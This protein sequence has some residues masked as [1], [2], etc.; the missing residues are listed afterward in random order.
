MPKSVLITGVSS[1]IGAALARVYLDRGYVVGGIARRRPEG[2]LPHPNMH[3]APA[4]LTDFRSV[5][6]A[7]EQLKARA[8]GTTFETLFLNAGVY[9]PRPSRAESVS[10]EAFM[11]VL[12]INVAG[13]KATMD[14]CLTLDH[15]PLNAIASASI[16]GRRP[17]M[18]MSTYATSK[19]ALNALIKVYQLEN[20]DIAFLALGM[21][22]VRTDL[23]HAFTQVGPDLRELF[24]LVQRA[25]QPGYLA[26]PEERAVSVAQV[27]DH[28]AAL[29]LARGEFHEM[30]ELLPILAT[31]SRQPADAP[32]TLGV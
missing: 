28:A 23:N 11:R 12:A 19:A 3:F 2:L 26:T 21:C 5:R 17:R 18:G 22:T 29:N 30:R 25:S 9:G 16:S 15:R 6:P 10:A 14:A 8:E 31:L 24:G 20:P 13:V 27:V 32:Q 1:G 4:D 7:I